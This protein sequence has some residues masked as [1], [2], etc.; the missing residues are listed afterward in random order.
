MVQKP[1]AGI[2]SLWNRSTPPHTATPVRGTGF[3]APP[4]LGD[5]LWARESSGRMYAT[6][7]RHQE[8][9]GLEAT[10]VVKLAFQ[11][12]VLTAARSGEVRLA[13][14]DEIDRAGAVWTIPAARMKAK[15]EH[16]V[17]LF[18]R[19][20]QIL[21]AHPD[22]RQGRGLIFPGA[23]ANRLSDMRFSKVLKDLGM[24]RTSPMSCTRGRFGS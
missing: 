21:D 24:R 10:R 7:H 9:A 14:W 22:A 1:P 2:G 17:P 15:R 6:G 23:R 11:F 19:A 8:G 13:P 20:A 16:R 18:R 4:N 12:L 5:G 3:G